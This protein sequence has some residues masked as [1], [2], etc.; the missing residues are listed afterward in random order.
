MGTSSTIS[1]WNDPWVS[2]PRPRSAIPN[3]QNQFLNPLL[4]VDDLIN[5]IE[6][7]WNVDLLKVYDNKDDVSIIRSL[8]ISRFL[9]T[10]SYRWYFTN[11]GRYSVKSGYRT[12]KT[13]LDMGFQHKEMGPDTK[14]LLAHS[15]KLKCSQK[16]KHFV[17][18]II[19]GS[20]PITKNLRS[21]GIKCDMQCQMCEDDEEFVNHVLF[22]PLALQTG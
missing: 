7:S 9:K 14:A 2:A 10:D 19:S 21:R 6:L 16:L 1:F 20:L 22:G 4:K 11:H 15:W 18:Q 8:A 3:F 13:Y 5:P 17:W 12:E